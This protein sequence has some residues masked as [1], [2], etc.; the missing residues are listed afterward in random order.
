MGVG[1]VQEWLTWN[2]ELG[3]GTGSDGR[4]R[5]GGNCSEWTIVRAT[6]NGMCPGGHTSREA[7]AKG[8]YKQEGRKGRGVQHRGNGNSLRLDTQHCMGS[9][10]GKKIQTP[11]GSN[12]KAPQGNVLW[13]ASKYRHA[14]NRAGRRHCCS[15]PYPMR[16]RQLR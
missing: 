15:K 3:I 9:C 13:K 8:V 7:N 1:C 11:R 10:T 5:E 12:K 6:T 2:G 16:G 4:M 14:W